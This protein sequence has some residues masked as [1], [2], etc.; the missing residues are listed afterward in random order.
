M[1][2]TCMDDR[3]SRKLLEVGRVYE[4]TI[5]SLHPNKYRIEFTREELDKKKL[6]I[7]VSTVRYFKKDRF[8]ITKK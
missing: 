8:I 5:D 4:A 6:S 2:V 7:K 3:G 1:L